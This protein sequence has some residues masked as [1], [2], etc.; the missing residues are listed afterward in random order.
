MNL[1]LAERSALEVVALHTMSRRSPKLQLK[2]SRMPF[3]DFS[4]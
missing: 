1:I 2:L 3:L 4:S